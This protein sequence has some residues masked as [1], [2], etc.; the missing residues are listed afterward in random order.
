[1]NQRDVERLWNE[2]KIRDWS[3]EERFVNRSIRI[4]KHVL[5]WLGKHV[6]FHYYQLMEMAE[7]CANDFRPLP[8][9][10]ITC[11]RWIT[12]FTR[13]NAPYGIRTDDNDQY[14]IFARRSI[15]EAQGT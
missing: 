13:V 4:R 2:G 15:I 12:Q 6:G 7:T 9:A 10:S 1:M 14:E 5:K 11:Y 8:C 3:A